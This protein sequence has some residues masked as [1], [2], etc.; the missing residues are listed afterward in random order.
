MAA[1]MMEYDGTS[2]AVETSKKSGASRLG[3]VSLVKL[4]E[5]HADP[6][7]VKE[8]FSRLA[9]NSSKICYASSSGCNKAEL[10][11]EF[12]AGQELFVSFV[13]QQLRC[14]TEVLL[15]AFAISSELTPAPFPR[16]GC[17]GAAT[18]RVTESRRERRHP[19]G[20]PRR[21]HES[22]AP[23]RAGSQG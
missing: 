12:G 6:L 22:R 14:T 18:S 3:S 21:Y 5:S 11:T 9:A 19:A 15:Q 16:K 23:R 2:R 13:K 10:S 7:G 8:K 1:G 4:R 20:Q 17:A